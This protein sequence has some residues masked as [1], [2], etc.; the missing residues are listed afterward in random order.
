MVCGN[1]LGLYYSFGMMQF[2]P[3]IVSVICF[4]FLPNKFLD[5]M[6]TIVD[7]KNARL[8]LK[9]VYNQGRDL[10]GRRLENLANVFFEMNLVFKAMLK[11]SLSGKE[12]NYNKNMQKRKN[13]TNKGNI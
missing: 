8:A 12:K 5:K 13:P 4:W 10:I 1:L 6:K 11:K 7:G 3:V 9:S 2:L